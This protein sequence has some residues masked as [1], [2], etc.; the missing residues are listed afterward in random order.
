MTYLLS[1][2][3]F[4]PLIGAF[5]LMVFGNE[6]KSPIANTKS[7][8]PLKEGDVDLEK[9]IEIALKYNVMPLKSV[10]KINGQCIKSCINI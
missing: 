1:Y 5:I 9:M 3:L 6:G 2:T 10:Q 8:E 7:V 4:L